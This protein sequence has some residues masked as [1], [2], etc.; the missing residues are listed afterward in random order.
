MFDFLF[1]RRQADT[2]ST[3]QAE[4]AQ[5]AAAVAAD[6]AQS[7]QRER[8]QAMQQAAAL[9]DEAGA[10]AF[11]V[12]CEFADARLQAAQWLQ[13]TEALTAA[14]RAVRNSDRRVAKLLQTRLDTLQRLQRAQAQMQM[15]L[16]QAEALLR[17]PVLTPDRAADMDRAWSA[18]AGAVAADDVLT[19]QFAAVRDALSQRLSRQAQLQRS[20]V[21]TRLYLQKI[22]TALQAAADE[23]AADSEFD[24]ISATL[25]R[26][27]QQ[28]AQAC[29]A[30]EATAL[31][32]QLLP[33]CERLV[34]ACRTMLVR[35]AADAA[36]RLLRLQQAAASNASTLQSG[37]EVPPQTQQLQQA[38][39]TQQAQQA[40][41][42]KPGRSAKPAPP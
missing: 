41:S 16:E 29:D 20:L 2:I 6:R 31:P 37:P 13:S 22:Q 35:A 24:A 27:Q 28:I 3:Q 33:D 7:R 23:S 8:E 17:D 5:A 1:K 9:A 4:D 30:P 12:Q 42:S 21:D 14:L 11:L 26:L 18:A 19:A 32:K 15:V 25:D 10:L 40:T 36:D 34:D 39:Q 38:E